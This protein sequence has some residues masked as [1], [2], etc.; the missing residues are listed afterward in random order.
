MRA[1]RSLSDGSLFIPPAVGEKTIHL[2][3]TIGD[4]LRISMGMSHLTKVYAPWGGNAAKMAQAIG[5]NQVTVRQWRNRPGGIPPKYWPKIIQEAQ[6][7]GHSL[8][9]EDFIPEVAA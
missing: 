8:T 3:L 6:S 1:A 2:G 7:L 9:A 4:T 5:V